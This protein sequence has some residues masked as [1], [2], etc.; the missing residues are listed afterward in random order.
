MAGKSTKPAAKTHKPQPRA[1]TF[2]C[3]RCEKHKP[4]SD[5][6]TVNR[7]VPALVVCRSCARELR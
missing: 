1:I 3:R 7:F 5:M 2:V 4:V 6:V